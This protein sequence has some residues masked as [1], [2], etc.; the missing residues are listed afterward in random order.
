[1]RPRSPLHSQNS[2]EIEHGDFVPVKRDFDERIHGA[3]A[4]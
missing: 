3:F 1:M 2:S 4:L